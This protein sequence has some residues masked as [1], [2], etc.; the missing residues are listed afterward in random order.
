VAV[1]TKAA[2]VLNATV[3][4]C[5]TG[6]FPA[7]AGRRLTGITKMASGISS[8][9]GVLAYTMISYSPGT[10]IGPQIVSRFALVKVV[11]SANSVGMVTLRDM[12]QSDGTMVN[13]GMITSIGAPER[14]YSTGSSHVGT[15]TLITGAFSSKMASQWSLMTRLTVCVSVSAPRYTD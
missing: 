1:P 14:W 8:P 6:I 3:E 11:I 15:V 10:A 2:A 12:T 9:R 7:L 4:I 13:A 5:N